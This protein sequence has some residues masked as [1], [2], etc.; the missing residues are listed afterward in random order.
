MQDELHRSDHRLVVRG[1]VSSFSLPWE[2]VFA[3][4]QRKVPAQHLW[5]ELPH[6]P[7]VV[8]AFVKVTV[9]GMVHNE[10]I[11]WVS[12]AK[13]RP[14]IVVVLLQHL[15]DTHHIGQMDAAAVAAAK[16]DVKERVA[17]TYGTTETSPLLSVEDVTAN[18][19]AHEGTDKP[20]T[21]V[22]TSAITKHA[23]PEV[24][25]LTLFH[26]EAYLGDHHPN[27]VSKDYCTAD[28]TDPEVQ[29]IAA[30][31]HCTNE[32]TID[33]GH[34]FWDQWQT[35]FLHWAFPYSI[36][37]EATATT[38]D[39]GSP[40]WTSGAP[41]AFG[42][43]SG[44]LH[45]QLLQRTPSSHVQMAF[46][47][48]WHPVANLASHKQGIAGPSTWV[49]AAEGLYQKL[50]KGHYQYDTRKLWYAKGLTTAE[51]E[52]LQDVRTI[53]QCIPGTIEARRRIGRFL[54]GARVELGEPLF[55]TISPTTRHN[56]FCIKFS[57]YRR[58][59]PGAGEH[60]GKNT[61]PLWEEATTECTLPS[62]ALRRVITARDPWA[63]VLSFQTIVRFIFARLL[64]IDMCFRCPNF[65]C[66]NRSGN[67]F[68]PC[69]GVLG[70]QKTTLEEGWLNNYPETQHD[71]LCQWPAFLRADTSP[72]PWL[73]PATATNV[74]SDAAQFVAA[75]RNH[76]QRNS[77]TSSATGILGTR[78][79]S[80]ACH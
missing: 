2:E 63:V 13:I 51:K 4:L 22:Q 33:T 11:E 38:P 8:R 30:L 17:A 77:R 55:I 64:G 5:A 48:E 7:D 45:P 9:K 24:P 39:G 18:N 34:D 35:P 67:S 46:R 70:V 20:D 78:P 27:V 42:R 26:G 60:G 28:T 44:K 71:S 53:Q 12:S 62:H 37:A 10:A 69:G 54:F 73:Q 57:R 23:T 19:Q 40:V 14:W 50:R 15:I 68:H 32:M 61:P 31:A 66:R 58:S 76:A 80:V 52:L 59:D 74:A 79:K 1:N 41:E 72:G 36:P 56:A 6:G 21:S 25:G 65:T 16:Q 49:Q 43:K 29:N 3:T 75:Y 47:V